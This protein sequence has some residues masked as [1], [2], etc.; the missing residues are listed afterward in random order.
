[1]DAR[2]LCAVML[3][4]LF[5]GCATAGTAWVFEKPGATDA[6][7][8]HDR[9]ECFAQAIGPEPSNPGALGLQISRDAYRA[10]MEGRGYRVRVA[11]IPGV[12]TGGR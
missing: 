7:V 12:P 3:L 4:M 11:M 6:Q 2:T 1:M 9:D 5:G 8:K 10:C